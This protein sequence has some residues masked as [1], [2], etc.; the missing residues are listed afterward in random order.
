MESMPHRGIRV[1]LQ[2]MSEVNIKYGGDGCMALTCL[3]PAIWAQLSFHIQPLVIY[4]VG[5]DHSL[6][7]KWCH[8]RF[9]EVAE[10]RYL[11]HHTAQ[12]LHTIMQ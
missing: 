9:R 3:P 11:T 1:L 5:V 4:Q 10:T 2:V 12:V 6:V 7:L 8:R